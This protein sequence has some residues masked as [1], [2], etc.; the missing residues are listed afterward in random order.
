MAQDFPHLPLAREQRVNER[1]PVGRG[2][3]GVN[4]PSDIRGH[5]GR[6]QETLDAALATA[7]NDLGGFDERKLIRFT[8]HKSFDA[9]KLRHLAS[10]IEL[11]SQED[12]TV[13]IGFA[14]DA[15]L[16]DFEARLSTLGGGQH[17]TYK[18]LI[19]ALQ[20]VDAWSTEDRTGW[21]LG[22]YGLP[23]AEDFV[24]DVELWPLD[25]SQQQRLAEQAA[26]EA[27]LQEEG[28]AQLDSV[29]QPGLTIYRVRCD[30]DQTDML[31][32]HRDVRT[33]DLPPSLGLERSLLFQDVGELPEVP[34]PEPDAP[35]ITVL[36]SGLATGHPLL[37]NAVGDIQSF[38][39]GEGAADEHGHGTHVAGLALYGDVE[40]CLR[41]RRFV[42]NLR[43]HSGR[44]LD[45]N[46]ENGTG[47]IENQI[48][49]AVGH[50][51]TKH[52]CRVFN[53]SFGDA[54][55]P[56]LGGHVRGLSVTLDT[57]ARELGVLFVV[58]T[59]N[60]RITSESP[61]GLAWRDDYPAYLLGDAWRLLEPA[62][63][64]NALTTGSLA[65]HD[66]TFNSQTNTNDP[67]ELPIARP[68]QPSPFTCG[69][70]S[71]GG[72][73]KPELVSHGGNWAVNA[74][75]GG[76]LL[77]KIAG[78]GV[79]STG[80]QFASGRPF[81]I[82][83][84][85][86]MAAP[87]VAHLAA[88]ILRHYPEADAN[89][90]RALLCAN[91][92]TPAACGALIEANN[93]F[94]RFCGYHEVDP[95]GLYRSFENAD[96]LI[97]GA[98]IE[99][100]RHHFYEIPIPEDFVRGG[101]HTRELA[102][103]L[104]YTPAVRTTRMHYK[105]SRIEFRVVTAP[106]LSQVTTMFNADTDEA[107]YENIPEFKKG[108][109]GQAARSKGTVQTDFWQFRLFTRTAKLRRLRLFVVVTRNDYPWGEALSRTEEPYAMVVSLRDRSQDD[110]HLYSQLRA[111]LELRAGMRIRL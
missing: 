103:S 88:S 98:A 41:N 1:R 65:R 74:R 14:S 68:G 19:Y 85:T 99:N 49:A 86:S 45:R 24:L 101:R 84:G 35:G 3:S 107:D 10:E 18:N 67:A 100:K 44:I 39:P 80:H 83:N 8:V 2:G 106:D 34:A 43:L 22:T 4:A 26:F 104:A 64:L 109:I 32:R 51:V 42:P 33:V 25:H 31:L 59:G 94:R 91:A 40:R 62:P 87:Q 30:P 89:L 79:I 63:A 15:G 102:V 60:H 21:A 96:T 82:E 73:I 23:D 81:A 76:T 111:E 75:A 13:V 97:T 93:E 57:L 105:A 78:L 29:K 77:D 46:N 5:T 16:R 66:R 108:M 69:G 7:T 11:V 27:W 56:Y 6:L 48:T 70:D 17:V 9:D 61:S 50:F 71:V 92:Q 55:K 36:D 12:R 53:L 54:N 37:R 72:A 90:L 52:G 58:S 95:A 38:L 47:F 110:V 20:S 28:V